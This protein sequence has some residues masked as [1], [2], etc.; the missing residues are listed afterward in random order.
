[1]TRQQ[2]IHVI[3]PNAIYFPEDLLRVCR[4]R[5]STIRREVR[6]GRLKVARRAGRYFILGSWL[7]DWLRSG[8]LKRKETT[9]TNSN[10]QL[11]RGV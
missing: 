7:L 9:A 8:E 11:A 6:E 5:K 10:G 1:M 3:E 2:P 4:L